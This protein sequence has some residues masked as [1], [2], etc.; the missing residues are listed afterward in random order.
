MKNTDNTAKKAPEEDLDTSIDYTSD[1]LAEHEESVLDWPDRKPQSQDEAL[2]NDEA[3]DEQHENL[4]NTTSAERTT[5]DEQGDTEQV[6]TETDNANIITDNEAS[7]HHASDKEHGDTDDLF[8]PTLR[9]E[10]DDDELPGDGS[11]LLS[12]PTKTEQEE[13]GYDKPKKRGLFGR[14]DKPKKA[15]KEKKATTKKLRKDKLASAGTAEFVDESGDEENSGR[16]I[17]PGKVAWGFTKVVATGA[18][19]TALVL[20]YTD[21]NG[22]KQRQLSSNSDI[23]E[24]VVAEMTSLEQRTL[25]SFTKL[26]EDIELF[27]QQ[28]EQLKVAG[29]LRDKQLEDLMA[30]SD[31]ELAIEAIKEMVEVD[32]SV[33]SKMDATIESLQTQMAELEKKSTEVIITKRATSK[34]APRPVNRTVSDIAGYSMFSVDLWGDTPMLVLIKGSEIKRVKEGANIDGWR[35]TSIDAYKKRATFQKGRVTNHLQG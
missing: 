30:G 26:Q 15:V 14:K 7:E 22:I 24:Q 16:T 20:L 27:N 4:N 13:T 23:R 11:D 2:A 9:S 1:P 8:V 28:F 35:L 5:D 6:K 19:A 17:H 32:R 34:P 25:N 29:Q 3:Q 31:S 10:K 33:I 12:N 21:V 18:M